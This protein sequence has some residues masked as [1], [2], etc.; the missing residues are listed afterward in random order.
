[1]TSKLLD[2]RQSNIFKQVSEN[3]WLSS[4]SNADRFFEWNTFFR[5]NINR[6]A[7]MYFGFSLYPYQHLEL[8][9]MNA[10]ST[11]VIVGSRAVAKSYVVAIF[12]CCKA[13][14]Y[15]GSQ[16]VIASATKSQSKLIVT[17]KIKNEL[18]NQSP[19]LRRE[20]E[21]I[22]DNQNDTVVKF[23]NGSTIKVVPANDNARGNRS[24]CIIYEEF[25]MI[26]KFIIDSVLS[27]FQIIRPVPYIKFKEYENL[28]EEPTDIYISSAWYSSHWMS[29]LIEETIAAVRKGMDQCILGFDYSITLKHNIKTRNQIYKDKKKFDPI[30]F[31]IE[32]ENQM[33]RENTAAYF[34][35]KMFTDNQRL[36]KPFYP[37]NDTD[38]LAKRK[39]PYA[40]PKQEGEIRIISCDMAFIENEKN[41]NSI[42]SC[43]RLIPET[44]SYTSQGSEGSRKEIKQGYRRMVPYL[45]PIQGGDTFKQ[46]IRIKQLFDDFEADYCVLDTRNAGIAIY[47]L[48]AKVMYD[49]SRDKEYS[50]WVC[51]NNENIAARIKTPGAKPVI[52]SIAASQKLN[53]DIAQDF[54]LSLVEN[55]IDFLV[56]FND[57][58]ENILSKIPEYAS[59]S[60][61]DTQIFYESPFLDTQELI[62]E[63]VELVY[64]KKPQTDIIVISEKGN[65]RKDRYTSVSYGNYF[66]SLLEQDLL[67]DC[68]SDYDYDFS[69]KDY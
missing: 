47:D 38:V 27:P 20:I 16:I 3:S 22:K 44:R 10:N 50:P 48:L 28:A 49:E 55:K 65:N 7:E 69:D 8:Y 64:E 61:P 25:R 6:Y 4:K 60:D 67:S 29:G 41:D 14:L 5:R 40:I 13:S 23:R 56:S 62:S 59:N 18:M 32:Y 66:A 2:A 12:G 33:I 42:F 17:E 1:M 9:E 51:F 21:S 36:R 53:S 37:R 58:V 39:N 31:A 45:E 34:K 57:A 52:Y 15:P 43:M 46:A 19:N 63:S 68:G 24:T 11:N 35:Y 54:R 26:N 30:T